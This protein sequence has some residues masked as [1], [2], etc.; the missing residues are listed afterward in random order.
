MLNNENEKNIHTQNF[1]FVKLVQLVQCGL[2]TDNRYSYE[3][4]QNDKK[5]VVIFCFIIK[6]G[7]LEVQ[8]ITKLKLTNCIQPFHSFTNAKK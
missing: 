3:L 2:C 6:K 4:Y 7:F 1:F 8:Q 5:V